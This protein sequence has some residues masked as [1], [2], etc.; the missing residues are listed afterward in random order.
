MSRPTALYDGDY[1]R[2]LDLFVRTEKYL[3]ELRIVAELLDLQ[4]GHLV[5][6]VGSGNGFAQQTLSEWSGA[7]IVPTDCPAAGLC[8]FQSPRRVQAD[9]HRLPF[10]DQ[11]FHRVYMLHAIGH[12]E[13]PS[14]VLR[15]ICRVLKPRG[16][17][18][19]V[20]PNRWFIYAHRPLNALGVLPYTPDPTVLHYF[21]LR[22]LARAAG[23]A[24]FD[25]LHARHAG[26]LP[27]LDEDRWSWR[28]FPSLRERIY[29]ALE[30]PPLPSPGASS[31]IVGTSGSPAS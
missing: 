31:L 10:R 24:G 15:E 19:L 14:G 2:R 29:C 20:T 5:L 12:V 7:T 8:L 9:G 26:R 23:Q 11:S 16:R 4:P 13:R 6:D 21:T 17:A 25:V 3:R 28:P 27:F 30:K 22:Q 18:V 1:F